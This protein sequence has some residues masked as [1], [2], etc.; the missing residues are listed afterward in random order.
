MFMYL[1]DNGYQ[2]FLI[3]SRDRVSPLSPRPSA[4]SSSDRRFVFNVLQRSPKRAHPVEIP[5]GHVDFDYLGR[6]PKWNNVIFLVE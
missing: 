2:F 1:P 5:A 6:E 3:R 4:L